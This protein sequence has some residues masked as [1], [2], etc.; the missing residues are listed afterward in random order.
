MTKHVPVDL[1]L[2][3]V[4]GLYCEFKQGKSYIGYD[5]NLMRRHTST[6]IE[7]IDVDNLLKR[8][9]GVWELDF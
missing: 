8:V 6:Y 9:R 3:F 7:S 2:Y 1:I 4:N 5:V